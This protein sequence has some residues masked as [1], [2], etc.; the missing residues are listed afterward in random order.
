MHSLQLLVTA[1][2]SHTIYVS[3][4]EETYHSRHGAITESKH[5]YIELG[6]AYFTATHPESQLVRIFEMGFGTGLNALLSLQFAIDKNISIEYHAIDTTPLDVDLFSRLNY[7]EVLHWPKG[8]K[9]LLEM[10]EIDWGS[11]HQIH[12]QFSIVKTLKSIRSFRPSAQSADL[13]YY[14]AFAPSKQEDVWEASLL[15]NMYGALSVG[16]LL[17]T[18]CA[19][20]QF[21]RDLRALGFEVETLDGP[22]GKHEVVRATKSS[23]KF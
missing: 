21:Q 3:E 9:Y 23:T 16:G 1:D 17:T 5:I 7:A 22:P 6:L 12:P 20:G 10:H 14:D 4:L 19:R 8:R 2:G 11:M 13:I 15:K 18:Y